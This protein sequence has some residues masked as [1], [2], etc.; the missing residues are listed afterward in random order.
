MLDDRH[1]QWW[2]ARNVAKQPAEAIG[3]ARLGKRSGHRSLDNGP[4]IAAQP[5][6]MLLYNWSTSWADGRKMAGSGRVS[7][8]VSKH[9]LG[10]QWR[11]AIADRM[12]GLGNPQA[13]RQTWPD[14]QTTS[15]AVGTFDVCS[16][17]A[18]N[19]DLLVSYTEAD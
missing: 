11:D 6:R 3:E 15:R 8:T 14:F 18:V 7:G 2:R 9:R 13:H 17:A 10:T 4:G 19:S 5:C 16:N 1:S 12:P